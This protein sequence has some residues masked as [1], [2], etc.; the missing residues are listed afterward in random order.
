[1]KKPPKKS[2]KALTK[3]KEQWLRVKWSKPKL[4]GYQENDWLQILGL[5]NKF[6]KNYFPE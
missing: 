1:M 4:L 3:T 6:A 5:I 2:Y